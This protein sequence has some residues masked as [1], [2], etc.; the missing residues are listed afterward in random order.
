MENMKE[1]DTEQ[2]WKD[3]E[4][5]HL[6]NCFS[7]D[8]AQVALGI[9]MSDE[10]LRD[11]L[12]VDLDPWQPNPPE[13]MRESAKRYNDKAEKIVGKRLLN[14][15]YPS[16]YSVFP[17]LKRIGEIFGGRY[18]Y[19]GGSEYLEGYVQTASD[20]EKLLDKV[21]KTDI[22]DFVFPNDWEKQVK[23]IFEKTGLK[24]EPR[25][26]GRHIRGPCTLAASIMGTENF[27]YFQYDEPELMRRFSGD[28]A[29]AIMNIN[30]AIDKACGYNEQN[31]PRGFSFADDNCCLTTAEFYEAFGYPV[32]KKV[33]DYYSPDQDDARYQHS[34]SDMA[35]LL[36]VLG[37]LNFN[38][39]NFGPNVLV[40]EIRKYM[41]NTRIDGCL[42]PY[43]FMRNESE[44]IVKQV[45]RDCKMAVESGIKGLNLA[46]AGSV[47]P[48]SSLASL[49]LVMQTIQNYGRYPQTR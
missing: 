5:A 7:K 25:F 48:G 16:K 18:F 8:A 19:R 39:V 40:D 13:L 33:F 41:P 26:F 2:F 32:L 46:T 36:P 45:K 44:E 9:R 37:R 17:Q 29:D 35:H 28:I 24:P 47:N 15:E 3:D 10:C 23:Q 43:A 42:A 27:I 12:G 22:A 20:L 4:T 38:G 1:L 34:D 14:E 31:K 30:T 6:N 11:E 49:R 21:E